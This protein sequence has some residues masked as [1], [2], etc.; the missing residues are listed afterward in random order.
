MNFEDFYFEVRNGN[1]FERYT[2]FENLI[3]MSHLNLF[4]CFVMLIFGAKIQIDLTSFVENCSLRS[5]S[6]TRQVICKLD[7]K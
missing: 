4:K 5:N 6:V 7:K 2:V 1:S 3:K